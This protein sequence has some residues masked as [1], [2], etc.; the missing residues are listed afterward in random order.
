MVQGDAIDKG[1]IGHQHHA[2][3][4]AGTW[5]FR[6]SKAGGVTLCATMRFFA[7]STVYCL[8]IGGGSA[9]RRKSRT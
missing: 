7:E 4:S 1:Q 6:V 2:V 5:G 9:A 8:S 3:L